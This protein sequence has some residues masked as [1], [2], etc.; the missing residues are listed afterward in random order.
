MTGYSSL[1]RY[2]KDEKIN[3]PS[4]IKK[5]SL[6]GFNSLPWEEMSIIG[7]LPNLEILKL[8]YSAIVGEIWETRDGEFQ[9]LRFLK[10]EGL[11][12]F[13][14]WD[15][16]FSSE[17]FPKLQQLVL[18]D[19]WKLQEIPCAM[20]EIET[21]QLIDVKRC[22]KSVGESAT[23]IEEEQRDMG[24]EDLRIII[25]K[26]LVDDDDDDDDGDD[27]EYDDDDDDDG[28]DGDDDGQ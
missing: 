12:N 15:I 18:H 14:K 16:S 2:M 28:D 22:Q 7:A 25:R 10:L 5:L 6:F 3:F 23:Q 19:C 20:G 21:L 13:C 1:N 4:N 24:N 8:G 17:H 11:Y 9:Q 26:I 27:D